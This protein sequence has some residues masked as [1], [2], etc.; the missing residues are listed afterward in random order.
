MKTDHIESKLPDKVRNKCVDT[1]NE[2]VHH[3]SLSEDMNFISLCLFVINY[4]WGK[5]V[6]I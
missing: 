1:L 3:K 5:Y 6:V 2:Y 4:L